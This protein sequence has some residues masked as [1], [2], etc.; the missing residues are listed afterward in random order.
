M[1]N[2]PPNDNDRAAMVAVF[3]LCV[4]IVGLVLALKNIFGNAQPPITYNYNIYNLGGSNNGT[5]QR[6]DGY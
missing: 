3:M 4:G 1:Q 6:F 2:S 5:I